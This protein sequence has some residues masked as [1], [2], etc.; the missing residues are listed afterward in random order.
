LGAITAA[1]IMFPPVVTQPQTYGVTL[2]PVCRTYT[3]AVRNTPDMQ[4][5][6]QAAMAEP[7]PGEVPA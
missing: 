3:G 4:A 5:W 1:D 2:S 6:T 7:P